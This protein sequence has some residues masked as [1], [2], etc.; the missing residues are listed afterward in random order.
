ME[1]LP[2]DDCFRHVPVRLFERDRPL[3]Q[4]LYR[5]AAASAS[6][7]GEGDSKARRTLRDLLKEALP[8]KDPDKGKL[9]FGKKSSRRWLG[10]GPHRSGK[11]KFPKIRP[12]R[13]VPIVA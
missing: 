12:L 13:V 9:H 2:G 11:S 5:A 1:V 4:G 7:S 10:M 6:S 8:D 3:L